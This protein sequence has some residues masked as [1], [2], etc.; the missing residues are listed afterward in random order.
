MKKQNT[1][2]IVTKEYLT[3]TFDRFATAFRN[4]IRFILNDFV[5]KIDENAKDYRNEI[6]SKLDGIAADLETMR[7]ENIIGNLQMKEL[8]TKDANHERRIRDIEKHVQKAA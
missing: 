1:S 3:K 4:E 5:Q 6:F 8:R 2:D 7:E